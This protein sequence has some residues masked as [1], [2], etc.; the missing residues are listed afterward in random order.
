MRNHQTSLLY[1][2]F[3]EVW[4]QGRRDSIDKLFATDGI[5]NGIGP[6]GQ[7]RGV[8][9]FK[10]FFNDF[11]EKFNEV[12]VT[13]EDVISQDDMES[14]LC[15]VTAIDVAS[16]KKVEFAGLCMVRIADG[17]I[18]EAWNHYDFLTMHQQLGFALQPKST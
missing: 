1:Q 12:H 18:A 7:M 8:E 2:W 5:A 9:A 17:Q 4:N 11:K 15:K 10:Q 16:G 6:E 13:V 14:A 3:N